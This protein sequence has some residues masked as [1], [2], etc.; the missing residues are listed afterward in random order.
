MNKLK[1]QRFPKYFKLLQRIKTK[2][3]F[4]KHQGDV[5]GSFADDKLLKDQIGQ[6]PQ[7]LLENL[8]KKLIECYK[9]SL[10]QIIYTNFLYNNSVKL[11]K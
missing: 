9:G 7:I 4:A 6:I 8:V 11:K 2:N 3:Y 10:L 1:C 5:L